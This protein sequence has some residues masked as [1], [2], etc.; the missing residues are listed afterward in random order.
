MG[1]GPTIEAR[2]NK[3]DAKRAKEFT[4]IAR[5][6]TVAAKQGGAD[7]EYNAALKAAIAKAKIV[8]MPNDNIDKAVKRGAGSN[9]ADN[10]ETVVYEGYGVNGVAVIVEALT[11]NRNRTGGNVRYFFDK[12]GGNLGTTGCV[13]YM[14]DRKGE[15]IIERTDDIDEDELMEKSI[16][17]GAEDFIAD[18]TGFQILT[19]TEDFETVREALT[20]EGYEFVAAEISMIPQTTAE[21][22]DENAVKQLTKMIDM[23]EDDDDIQH[24]WTNWER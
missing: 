14:F 4:K 19:A 11:D 6:I 10:F 9:D 23:M 15:I 24:V 20:A 8:N 16:E 18:E 17:V 3:Q 7:P 2:K 5:V 21:V 22:A 13:S 1:R 12:N